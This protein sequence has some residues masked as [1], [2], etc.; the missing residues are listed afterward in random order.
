[1]PCEVQALGGHGI[2]QSAF[3]KGPRVAL[4]RGRRTD[5]PLVVLAHE[6]A[7]HAKHLRGLG[8]AVVEQPAAAGAEEEAPAQAGEAP[9]AGVEQLRRAD[10]PEGEGA[11]HLARGRASL[12][13]AGMASLCTSECARRAAVRRARAQGHRRSRDPRRRAGHDPR[14]FPVVD[15]RPFRFGIRLGIAGLLFGFVTEHLDA[16]GDRIWTVVRRGRGETD[17]D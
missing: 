10:F 13:R 14:S 11:R 15:S 9:G 4:T 16:N 7:R 3:G 12:R 6:H 5:R 1:V 2:R 17:I 8:R